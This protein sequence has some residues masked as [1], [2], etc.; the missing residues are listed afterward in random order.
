[1]RLD[2]ALVGVSSS[3]ET[4]GLYT[5][6][7]KAQKTF[8]P[9]KR[10]GMNAS[11]GFRYATFADICDA[12]VPS[13]LEA[14]LAIPTFSMGWDEK[15]GRWVLVG[16]L[17]HAETDQWTS[18]VCPLLLGFG[19]ND[20]P[21]VQTLEVE[22]T[23]AK[24]ILMANLVGGW[25]E[26]EGDEQPKATTIDTSES[27]VAPEPKPEKP[28]AEPPIPVVKQAKS[29]KGKPAAKDMTVAER[30]DAKLAE[31]YGDPAE[32]EKIFKH[33]YAFEEQGL[34][35]KSDITLLAAKH[36]L[37]AKITKVTEVP[38]V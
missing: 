30:A 25:L 14:G 34:I 29:S 33:L 20:R 15:V 7:V 8:K 4:K 19:P 13:L 28:K 3:T 38:S 31:V 35:T 17:C 2:A 6:L 5:A 12:V 9:I 27:Q 22:N 16:T 23:Y 24:K 10:S 36:K 21:G 18:A 32:V 26:S 37:D 11:E 1:M